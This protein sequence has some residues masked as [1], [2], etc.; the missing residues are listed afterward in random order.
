M[1]KPMPIDIIRN[2]SGIE[3]DTDATAAAPSR[4]TQ[5]ASTS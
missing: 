1:V 2:I 4:P 5:N 3:T